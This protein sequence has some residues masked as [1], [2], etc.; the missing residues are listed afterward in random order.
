MGAASQVQVPLSTPSA[1]D[2]VR[3]VCLLEDQW[4]GRGSLRPCVCLQVL[5]AVE[6]GETW[7]CK[8]VLEQ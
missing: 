4:S 3:Q 7:T 5:C 2:W 8:T 6:A 1:V